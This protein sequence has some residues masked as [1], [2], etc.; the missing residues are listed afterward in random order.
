M[1]MR[2]HAGCKDPPGV[3]SSTDHRH[4]SFYT[5][6]AQHFV[7]STFCFLALTRVDCLRGLWPWRPHFQLTARRPRRAAKVSSGAAVSAANRCVHSASSRVCL[8]V[9]PAEAKGTKF[10]AAP[11]VA[12]R[13]GCAIQVLTAPWGLPCTV[14][15]ATYL[16][17]PELNT[18]LDITQLAATAGIKSCF[19]HTKAGFSVF[20]AAA[21]AKK[22]DATGIC[23]VGDF[24][25]VSH[26]KCS[27]HLPSVPVMRLDRCLQRY[28][29]LPENKHAAPGMR[30][31]CD[32]LLC[33][34]RALCDLRVAVT[35]PVS[36]ALW[37][38]AFS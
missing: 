16:V 23:T 2:A 8:C 13:C 29:D 12:P 34:S 36:V 5:A 6:Q 25:R 15:A 30:G 37:N 14:S 9:P 31:G 21:F 22:L 32:M 33:D 26:A 17:P 4:T 20:A 1:R 18:D 7:S 24:L 19:L 3:H 38:P 28:P 35:V 27:S 10:Q 11:A